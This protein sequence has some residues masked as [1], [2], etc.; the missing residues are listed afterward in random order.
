MLLYGVATVRISYV[1]LTQDSAVNVW[2]ALVFD[3]VQGTEIF[4]NLLR[5]SLRD[6][7]DSDPLVQALIQRKRKRFPD[8]M[9]AIGD[10][11]IT[12][13]G[14]ELRVRAQARDPYTCMNDRDCPI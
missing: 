2:N 6:R 11:T 8:D 12:Y 14:G 4:F 3:T 7:L 9:R 13:Q 5:Q 1:T 10:H